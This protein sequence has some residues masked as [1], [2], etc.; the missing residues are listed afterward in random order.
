MYRSWLFPWPQILDTRG[1]GGINPCMTPCPVG[2]SHV[3]APARL[4]PAQECVVSFFLYCFSLT[5]GIAMN[6]NTKSPWHVHYK[7]LF[8]SSSWFSVCVNPLLQCYILSCSGGAPGHRPR[9]TNVQFYEGKSAL[10]LCLPQHCTG[11]SAMLYWMSC[12]VLWDSK[13]FR[14][15]WWLIIIDNL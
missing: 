9:R 15:R 11:C 13:G 4:I 6:K 8:P 7:Y 5:I 2:W 3:R 1:E 12:S 14:E 10:D